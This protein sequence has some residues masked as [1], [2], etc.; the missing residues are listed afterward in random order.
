MIQQKP[1]F[2]SFS[3]WL[4]IGVAL[5]TAIVSLIDQGT[6]PKEGLIAGLLP[7]L[8]VILKRMSNEN[9]VTR[10]NAHIESAKAGAPPSN[11]T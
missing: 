3:N 10:A 6:I 5:L 9:T 1:W 8:L 7:A 4:A 11:P 2:K